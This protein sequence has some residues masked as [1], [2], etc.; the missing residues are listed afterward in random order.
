MRGLEKNSFSAVNYSLPAALLAGSMVAMMGVYPFIA[1]FL[2]SGPTLTITAI[3]CAFAVL[4][5][6]GS[7]RTSGGG[8]LLA[9]AFPLAALLVLF[10]V[11]RATAMTLLNDGISW[12]DTRYTLEELKTNR[13]FL[14]VGAVNGAGREQPDLSSEW[15]R[16]S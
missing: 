6:A 7:T 16:G 11:G 13:R 9:P 5:F 12:R 3:T 1:L 2:T 15:R 10:I 4:L 14:P 8:I